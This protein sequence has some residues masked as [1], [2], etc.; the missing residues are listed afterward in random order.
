MEAAASKILLSQGLRTAA[1]RE[2]TRTHLSNL[3]Q[4]RVGRFLDLGPADQGAISLLQL[5][6]RAPA[7][8][9]E[10]CATVGA[11]TLPQ[12]ARAARIA[13]VHNGRA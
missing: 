2:R 11:T 9:A 7:A 3:S 8:V 10:T 12:T 1:P 5:P 6:H 13:D 4:P